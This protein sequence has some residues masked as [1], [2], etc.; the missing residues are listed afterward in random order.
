MFTLPGIGNWGRKTPA[1]HEASPIERIV[2]QRRS[3]GAKQT[4]F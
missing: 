4:S 2:V 1:L 3:R